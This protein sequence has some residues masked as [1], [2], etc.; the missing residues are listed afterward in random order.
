MKQEVKILRAAIKDAVTSYENGIAKIM[1]QNEIEDSSL[2]VIE[3][4]Q[5]LVGHCSVILR[6][7]KVAEK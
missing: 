4:S 1:E 3:G 2:K 6:K 7:L 5:M